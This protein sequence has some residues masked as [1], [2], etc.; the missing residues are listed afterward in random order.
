MSGVSCA[1]GRRKSVADSRRINGAG[2]GSSRDI[3][4]SGF[5]AYRTPRGS[6]GSRHQ[7]SGYADA[8]GG[9][10][11]AG[12]APLAVVGEEVEL[13]GEVL[14]VE[15]VAEPSEGPFALDRT[16]S[17]NR[18]QDMSAFTERQRETD[19]RVRRSGPS[20]AK[21]RSGTGRPSRG[22]P[23]RR[24]VRTTRCPAS[25]CRRGSD[26]CVGGEPVRRVTTTKK[27]VQIQASTFI[28][29]LLP[30]ARGLPRGRPCPGP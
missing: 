3:R 18:W 22:L 4:N 17:R 15:E 20:K 16:G 29:R 5:S 26:R 14:V 28:G 21:S 19:Q 30:L 8:V 9:E 11:N 10:E 12:E 25:Q 1:G 2:F 13:L 7:A 23:Q 6:G 27:I 24:P